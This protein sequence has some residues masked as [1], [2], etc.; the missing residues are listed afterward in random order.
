MRKFPFDGVARDA[1]SALEPFLKTCSNVLSFLLLSG[2]VFL[3]FP[4]P[5]LSVP[6]SLFHN[7][8]TS[9]LFNLPSSGTSH[10]TKWTERAR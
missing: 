6:V 3:A 4:T 10:R 1:Y 2:D 8:K 9:F 5:F 7:A